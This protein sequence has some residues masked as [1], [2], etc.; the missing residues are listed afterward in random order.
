MLRMI[1][2]KEL[3]EKLL[4]AQFLV[5]S[6][7]S[8][9]L[10][11]ATIVTLT[12]SYR[13]EVA[14]YNDRQL[15]QEDFIAHYGHLNRFGWMAQPL[16]PPPTYGF[17]VEGIDREAKQENFLS[18]P[19][20]VLF[21]EID[22]IVIVTTI[23]SLFGIL[24]SFNAI[25]GE[26]EAGML[27]QMLSTNISRSTILFGKFIGGSIGLLLPFAIGILG[28]LIFISFDSKIQ[29]GGLDFGVFSLIILVSCIYLSFFYALG[30]YFSSRSQSSGVAML[31]SLFAW[32]VL[33]L[34]LPN[35]SPFLAARLYHLPSKT[36]ID[37]EAWSITSD[38]RDKIVAQRTNEMIRTKYA[39]IAADLWKSSAGVANVEL[40]QKLDRDPA[41]KARF[42]QYQNNWMTMVNQVNETQQ[43]KSTLLYKDFEVRSH[44]QEKIAATVA[45]ISPYGNYVFIVS[46]LTETGIQA[47]NHWQS[48][49]ENYFTS[50]NPILMSI[51]NDAVKKNPRFSVND[52]L[53]LRGFPR[54]TYQ[55]VPLWD[56]VDSSLPQVGVLVF[57]NILF[58]A[59]AWMSF[60]KYDVR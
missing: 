15:T 33:V 28:G 6:A 52:F 13:D 40:R 50:M 18:N 45:S 51:Y 47:D 24:S 19:M 16:R 53:D 31:K 5:A 55:P 11:I 27:R 41:L 34:L 42:A 26:R 21:S 14:D 17:L 12:G 57:F 23:L 10:I 29:L 9:L 49:R 7:I 2:Q 37:M 8:V 44:Y 60:M 38:E 59:G 32:V 25:C 20:P 54:F 22:L 43:A 36:K 56:K 3:V 30:L 58:L 39:D 48:Q 35:I 1:I 46:D 4:N